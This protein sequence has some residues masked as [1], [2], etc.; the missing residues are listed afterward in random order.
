MKK[1]NLSRK[2]APEL[3]LLSFSLSKLFA[4]SLVAG[5]V[6]AKNHREAD[7]VNKNKKKTKLQFICSTLF[8]KPVFNPEKYL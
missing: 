5:P 1:T 8:A 2:E 7:S 6:A 3:S 4:A